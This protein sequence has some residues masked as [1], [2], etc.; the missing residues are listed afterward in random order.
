M[1]LWGS[2]QVL[3]NMGCV[4]PHMQCV[5]HNLWVYVWITQGSVGVCVDHT[6]QCGCMCGSHKAVWV[7]VWITQGSVGVCVDHTRQCGCMCGSSHRQRYWLCG[8]CF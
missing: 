5:V 8:C 4:H 1:N 7:Y 3:I 6:R 2:S